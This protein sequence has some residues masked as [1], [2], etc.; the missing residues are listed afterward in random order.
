MVE[1][2]A[3]VLRPFEVIVGSVTHLFKRNSLHGVLT[4][5]IIV[6]KGQAV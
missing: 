3:F 2:V 6:I 4:V 1:Y 5:S